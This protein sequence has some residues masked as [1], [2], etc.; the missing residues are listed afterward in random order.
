MTILLDRIASA[1][2]GLV[3]LALAWWGLLLTGHLLGPSFVIRL[4]RS[5]QGTSR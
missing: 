5:L 1:T 4:Q 2:L 3:H